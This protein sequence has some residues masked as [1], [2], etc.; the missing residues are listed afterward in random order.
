M[1]QYID[2]DLFESKSEAYVNAVNCV[3]VMGGGGLHWS[4]NAVSQ[5][6]LRS[7]R[8]FAKPIK[9]RLGRCI[10]LKRD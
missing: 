10:Y 1:I 8:C 2:S 5:I 9:S 3:G 7:I 4:L 6:C